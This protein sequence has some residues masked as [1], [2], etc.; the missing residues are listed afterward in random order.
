MD[1]KIKEV[2]KDSWIYKAFAQGM[3]WDPEVQG[4][5]DEVNQ[6]LVIP[7]AEEDPD[8]VTEAMEFYPEDRDNTYTQLKDAWNKVCPEGYTVE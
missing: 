3:D 5:W 7:Y 8:W 1:I 2:S 4:Y 6:E